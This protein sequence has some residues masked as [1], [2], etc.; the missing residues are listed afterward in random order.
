MN[1]TE[2]TLSAITNYKLS[3]TQRNRLV[4]IISGMLLISTGFMKFFFTPIGDHFFYLKAFDTFSDLEALESYGLSNW[5]VQILFFFPLYVFILGIYFLIRG[6]L[7]SYTAEKNNA[8][9]FKFITGFTRLFLAG[10]LLIAIT[11][12]GI[13]D[14]TIP[15]SSRLLTLINSLKI[16]FYIFLSVEV[17][18]AF[19]K[20]PLLEDT[21]YN[22]AVEEIE[23]EATREK[24][25]FNDIKAYYL[26]DGKEQKGP[27]SIK[28]LQAIANND[29]YVWKEGLTEWMLI[30]EVPELKKVFYKPQPPAFGTTIP[31]FPKH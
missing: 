3:F 1:S 26:H 21:Q 19:L 12:I 30:S 31:P 8:V 2:N 14:E 10:W 15:I 22:E 18:Q 20:L 25:G 16:G 5:L 27:Y 17:M 6:L 11:S 29:D 13:M 23:T 28:E 4:Y 7:L 9:I 24:S